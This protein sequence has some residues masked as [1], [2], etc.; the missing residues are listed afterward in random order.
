MNYKEMFAAMVFCSVAFIGLYL[1][2]M[3]VAAVTLAL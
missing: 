1:W 2:L 3:A